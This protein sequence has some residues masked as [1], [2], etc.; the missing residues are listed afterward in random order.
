MRVAQQCAVCQA[1]QRPKTLKAPIEHAPIPSRAMQSVAL[2]I[3]MMPR[4]QHHKKLYDAVMVCVDRHTGWIVAVP[5]KRQ[6]LTA[7]LAATKMLK[8]QWSIFGVPQ[9]ITTDCGSQFVGGWFETLLAGLGIRHIFTH[10]YF[11]RAAGRVEVANQILQETLRK[12]NVEGKYTWVEALPAALNHIH[13]L[14]GPTG[15]SP[16]QILFGRERIMGNV[17]YTPSIENEDAVDFF[18]RMKELDE[19]VSKTLNFIHE[20]RAATENAKV[21]SPP[22]FSVGQKVWYR[23]PEGSGNKLDS[24]WLG[25]ALIDQRLGQDSYAVRV[26]ERTVLTAP[27]VWIKPYLEDEMGGE[28]LPLFFH[29]RTVP[30]P[31]ALPDEWVVDKVIS[32]RKQDGIPHFKVHWEGFEEGDATWEAPN[33]FF[34]RYAA[35]VIKYCQENHIPLDVTKFL[36]PTPH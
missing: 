32:M 10:P 14:P 7:A 16:Y 9:V 26:G 34:H 33:N 17:P 23:R 6:G 25:P 20:K 30:D 4:V 8:H 1:C 21:P 29:K 27:A 35:P 13:N 19:H 31:Q 5:V 18:S 11:H 28:E 2:D 24:R 36:S 15:L 12:I 3:M 22:E